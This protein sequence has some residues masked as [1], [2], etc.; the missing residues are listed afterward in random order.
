MNFW[1]PMKGKNILIKV[2][3][4]ESKITQIWNI[5]IGWSI[6]WVMQLF[7]FRNANS[8]NTEV[9]LWKYD[10]IPWKIRFV[11]QW[12]CCRYQ[13]SCVTKHTFC[14]LKCKGSILFSLFSFL[15]TLTIH[16]S[17][18]NTTELVLSTM[19]YF[20]NRLKVNK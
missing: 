15:C 16:L 11:L 12:W 20:H 8:A 1:L 2:F 10:M 19:I 9:Y 7:V 3:C 6:F 14:V 17:C 4:Y 13:Q 5:H 18:S